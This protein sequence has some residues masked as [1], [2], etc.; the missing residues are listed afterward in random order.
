MVQSTG[1]DY[2]NWGF[3]SQPNVEVRSGPQANAAVVERLGIHFV[4][5]LTDA[6]APQQN[7][8]FL[9]IVTPAGKVGYV[10]AE[11][12]NPI[13]SDQLCFAKDASGA[14]KIGGLVGG[15]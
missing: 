5:V 14:W 15:E 12:I 2:G 1:S 11:E 4:W 8:D 6:A 3:T 9:R 13:G 7:Q 10:K